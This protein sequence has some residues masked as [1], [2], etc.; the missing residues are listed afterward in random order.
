MVLTPRHLGIWAIAWR[1]PSVNCLPQKPL[2]RET[3]PQR[4]RNSAYS[5]ECLFPPCSVLFPSCPTSFLSAVPDCQSLA[6][7]LVLKTHLAL[8]GLK[9][10]DGIAVVLRSRKEQKPPSGSTK[11][12]GEQETSGV[13][14]K[15]SKQHPTTNMVLCLH[16]RHIFLKV[17]HTTPEEKS[18]KGSRCLGQGGKG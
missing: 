18:G 11:S 17:H 12:A 2:H 16:C 3:F 10:V 6:G 7:I 8:P 15:G 14:G 9:Q 5:R 13:C 1:S 4:G